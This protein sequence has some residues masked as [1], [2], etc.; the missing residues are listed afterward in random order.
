MTG[1]FTPVA[2]SLFPGEMLVGAVRDGLNEKTSGSPVLRSKRIGAGG[3]ND[4]P[5]VARNVLRFN[6]FFSA[7]Y[8]Q[9]I[10]RNSKEM[11]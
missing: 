6:R 10:S 9:G 5:L 3:L 4:M 7:Q 1:G 2:V 11:P 8:L